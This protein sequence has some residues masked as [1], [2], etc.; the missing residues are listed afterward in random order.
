MLFIV[1]PQFFNFRKKEDA[2]FD[3]LQ[4]SAVDGK[5]IGTIISDANCDQM[6][7]HSN[8]S[9][10][11]KKNEDGTIGTAIYATERNH[12]D[13]TV[14]VVAI[15]YKGY[16]IPYNYTN[17][18][19]RNAFTVKY[20]GRLSTHTQWPENLRIIESTKS[21][22]LVEGETN[23]LYMVLEPNAKVLLERTHSQHT[24][25][26][27]MS[28]NY[29]AFDE[30]SDRIT[31]NEHFQIDM[32]V[33]KYPDEGNKGELL[34]SAKTQKNRYAPAVMSN[35]RSKVVELKNKVDT[36]NMPFIIAEPGDGKKTDNRRNGAKANRKKPA[37]NNNDRNSHQ[38]KNAENGAGRNKN[39][40][41]NR[42]D[43]QRKGGPRR[44]I[45]HC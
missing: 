30:E 9:I 19:I 34:V 20:D 28:F 16:L 13:A 22:E 11:T 23:I 17:V 21:P 44:A 25:S 35:L 45:I 3:K 39:Y 2:N 37:Y 1:N 40:R 38:K 27:Y 8:V 5:Y 18:R 10:R 41:D 4:M 7:D 26:M 12:H 15:P 24:E 31:L 42:G 14:I 6:I 33:L 32:S 43:G 36:L 29:A